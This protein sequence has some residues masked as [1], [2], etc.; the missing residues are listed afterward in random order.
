MLNFHFYS[1]QIPSTDIKLKQ[2]YEME[3]LVVKGY[4][5]GAQALVGP[6]KLE[7]F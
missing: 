3:T 5:S 4:L 6:T 1:F 7:R 2:I